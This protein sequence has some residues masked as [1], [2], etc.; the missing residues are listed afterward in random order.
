MAGFVQWLAPKLR[1]SAVYDVG[2]AT[3]T[4]SRLCNPLWPRADFFLFEPLSEFQDDLLAVT[5]EIRHSTVLP[6][7]LLD[8]D[9]EME[10]NVHPD[11]EGSSVFKEI[12][13]G[14]VDGFPRTVACRTLDRWFKSDCFRLVKLDVQ[15]A[16]IRALDG[17]QSFFEAPVPDTQSETVFI[18]EVN[19]YE[20]MI[21]SEN[22]FSRVVSYFQHRNF[23]LLDIAGICRR[24]LDDALAQTDLVFCHRESRL[25]REKAFATK[26]SV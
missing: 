19:L 14:L 22:L 21:G 12:E 20:N 10:L 23:E 7:A 13:G 15:G 3:G 17:A 9:G 8:F 26:S 1:I 25:R 2:A 16:E 11:L 6:F 18:V 5:R 4:F 24:P